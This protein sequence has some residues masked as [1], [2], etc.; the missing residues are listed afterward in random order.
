[1]GGEK[2]V[3]RK[4]KGKEN[5][6]KAKTWVANIKMDLGEIGWGW[7]GLDLSGSG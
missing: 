7:C 3:G 2:V 6:R 1:M 4:A 5:T